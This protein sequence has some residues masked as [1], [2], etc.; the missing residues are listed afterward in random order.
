MFWPNLEI[1]CVKKLIRIV[2]LLLVVLI[3]DYEYL[4]S[5]IAT[6]I[7]TKA[8]SQSCARWLQKNAAGDFLLHSMMMSS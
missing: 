5:D 6:R 2:L 8:T 1:C 7:G 3:S 4:M